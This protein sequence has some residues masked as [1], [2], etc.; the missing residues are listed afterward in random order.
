MKKLNNYEKLIVKEGIELYFS[1]LI[2]ELKDHKNKDKRPL[3]T[4]EYFKVIKKELKNKLGI[5]DN[6]ENNG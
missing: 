4:P 2:E 6:N 1:K 5:R 3:F